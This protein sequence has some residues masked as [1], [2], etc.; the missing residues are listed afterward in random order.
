MFSN[1]H[2]PHFFGPA[3]IAVMTLSHIIS[4]LVKQIFPSFAY[5]TDL[6][7]HHIHPKKADRQP[8]HSASVTGKNGLCAICTIFFKKTYFYQPKSQLTFVNLTDNLYEKNNN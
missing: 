3:F 7:S 1:M 2:S 5:E 6:C 8:F 4:R